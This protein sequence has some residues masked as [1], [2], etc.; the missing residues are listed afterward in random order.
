[1]S[2]LIGSQLYGRN[3]T[4][5]QFASSL[6]SFARPL[7]TAIAAASNASTPA[8]IA[9]ATTVSLSSAGMKLL[10]GIGR[11]VEDVAKGAIGVATEAVELPFDVVK[12]VAKGIGDATGDAGKMLQDISTGSASELA[13]D[14]STFAHDLFV[15]VP[16]NIGSDI[17]TDTKAELVDAST[18]ASGL[19]GLASLGATGGASVLG[20]TA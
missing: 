19:L 2:S 1:M 12:D 9:T 10:E 4:A 6:R 17:A 7:E 5:Q 20:T 13:S 8:P 15:D 11:S 3:S 16:A 18:L 14:A